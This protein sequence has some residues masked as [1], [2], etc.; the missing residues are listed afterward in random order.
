MSGDLDGGGGTSHGFATDPEY[1]SL[2]Q[3]FTSGDGPL[4]LRWGL[5]LRTAATVLVGAYATGFAEFVG[6]L[7]SLVQKPLRKAN[8]LRAELVAG[9]FPD[10]GAL[11]TTWGSIRT[12]VEASGVLSLPIVAAFLVMTAVALAYVVD[13][14]G[15]RWL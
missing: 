14:G 4:G 9:L 2:Y 1:D 11:D 10:P 7:F 5:M 15:G 8:E 12:I 13:I 3:Q 6:V